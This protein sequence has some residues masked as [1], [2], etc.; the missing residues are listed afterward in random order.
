MMTVANVNI[1][2]QISLN[3]EEMY[4]DNLFCPYI[5][6]VQQMK[7]LSILANQQTITTDMLEWYFPSL[8]CPRKVLTGRRAGF[9]SGGNRYPLVNAGRSYGGT[10]C[11]QQ[12]HTIRNQPT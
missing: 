7:G 9:F 8:N 10:A 12:A 6:N 2:K 3:S 1:L 5:K 11:R 4:G